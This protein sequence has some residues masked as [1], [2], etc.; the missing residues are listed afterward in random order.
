MPFSILCEFMTVVFTD[1]E[2]GGEG[3]LIELFELQGC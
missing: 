2:G 1:N 3:S